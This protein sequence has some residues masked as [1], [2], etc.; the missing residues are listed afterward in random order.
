[1]STFTRV[2]CV[3]AVVLFLAV[4]ASAQNL[5]ITNARVLDGTGKV[6]ERGTVV[7]RDGKIASVSAN[8]PPAGAGRTIDAGGKTVMPGFIDAH[9][10]LVQGNPAQWLA[11]Q[12]PR[13]FQE[14]LE[15]GFTTVVSAIDP[16]Q[17]LEARN[18]IRE[19]KMRGPRLFAGAFDSPVGS[20]ARRRRQAIRLAPI[21]RAARCRLHAPAIPR[22]VTIKAVEAAAQAGYDYLKIVMITHAERPGGRDVE[23]RR[24]GRQ[25]TQHADHHA[26][27]KH[28]RHARGRRGGA[29]CAR[30][31]AAH[32]QSW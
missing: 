32:R 27:R 13:Q 6:I 9:R 26:R 4:G 31:H 3:T 23:A 17:V 10:H 12:A 14:F 30:A 1:M 21:R 25:E 11:Q 5:V 24:A 8:A 20:R 18:R 16:P 15:A 28:P 7:V 22:D 29:R 2:S 19:G